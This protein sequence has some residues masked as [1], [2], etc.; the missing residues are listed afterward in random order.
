MILSSRSF[1]PA[2]RFAGVLFLL[3]AVWWSIFGGADDLGFAFDDEDYIA[4][5]RQAQED[6]S[7]LVR[8]SFD[9]AW[10]SRIGVHLY[11]FVAYGFFGDLP[12]PYHVASAVFHLLNSLILFY[13]VVRYQG[14]WKIGTVAAL[15]FLTNVR[16]LEAVHWISSVSH[17][18]GL[19]FLLASLVL[20]LHYCHELRKGWLVGAM[21][22]FGASVLC[23]QAMGM[24]CLLAAILVAAAG[25]PGR[26][27][28][29]VVLAY[30]LPGGAVLILER[31]LYG[32]P[33]SGHETYV[34]M[35]SHLLVNCANY[36][37][38]LFAG[39]HLDLT[40]HL[41]LPRNAEQWIGGLSVA[42]V[43][44]LVRWPGTRFWAL[45]CL[46]AIVPFA[47]W[48]QPSV[49]S[50]YFYFPA[51]GSSVLLATG[52]IKLGAWLEFRLDRAMAWGV[53]GAVLLAT[54]VVSGF[55][56][57]RKK[58]VHYYESGKYHV[59]VKKDNAR[60]I[61]LL[62]EAIRRDAG[63]PS[64]ITFL[65]LGLAYVEQKRYDLAEE[66]VKRLLH[67]EP[68][69]ARAHLLMSNILRKQGRLRE[70]DEWRARAYHLDPQV[71][72][73]SPP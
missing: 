44:P 57:R 32:A 38:G 72:R 59:M 39:A 21:G 51:A 29:E 40:Y 15:L 53:I 52:L 69:E 24:G 43:L 2:A 64:P 55:E 50:R 49:F 9:K 67:R 6:L 66:V 42:L 45:W 26:T 54:V 12:G 3:I 17:V 47:F 70:A 60:A 36:A 19:S 71:N 16:H 1:Q 10:A 68:D 46:L 13:L 31:L 22:C 58:S 35:G 14:D 8:P 33:F 11:I 5:A 41:G 48:V 7:L 34:L 73:N 27:Q 63:V 30:L 28:V 20:L 4:N 61:P 25:R 62:A 23:H 18:L 56:L 37:F 65:W